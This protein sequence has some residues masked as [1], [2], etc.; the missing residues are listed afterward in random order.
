VRQLPGG[1]VV[2]GLNIATADATQ[3]GNTTLLI[4]S[5]R[6]PAGFPIRDRGGSA[7]QRVAKDRCRSRRHSTHFAATVMPGSR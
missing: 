6:H 4:V 5:E 2:A 7:V 1:V 3:A